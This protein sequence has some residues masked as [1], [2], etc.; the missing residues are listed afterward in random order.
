MYTKYHLIRTIISCSIL[1]FCIFVFFFLLPRLTVAIDTSGFK[2][3]SL[4]S[5]FIS[6][7]VISLIQ[8]SIA[9]HRGEDPPYKTLKEMI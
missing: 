2:L 3:L 6:R 4:M 7:L 9:I 1:C 8:N 5:L